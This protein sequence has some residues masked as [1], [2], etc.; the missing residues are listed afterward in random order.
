MKK[1]DLDRLVSSRA[2]RR[3][4]AF[5]RDVDKALAGRVT[6]IVLFGSRAR[7]DATADS[8][9]DVAV[10][11]RDLQDRRALGRRLADIAYPH[12][13]EGIHIRPV[14][15]PDDLLESPNTSNL[16]STILRD[17]ITIP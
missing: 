13:L 7:G 17:G 9:Y 10:F 6:D 14:A 4:R 8:D 15:V 1:R 16:V 5:R 11:V 12:I 3:L 2:A